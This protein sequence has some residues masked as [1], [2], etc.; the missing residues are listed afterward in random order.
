MRTSRNAISSLFLHHKTPLLL[1]II[2]ITSSI[3]TTILTGLG[4]DI[5]TDD[6]YYYTIVARNFAHTSRFTFD[7]FSETN[8]Y[9]PLL[10]WLQALLAK[11]FDHSLSSLS[12][13]HVLISFF[14]IILLSLIPICLRFYPTSHEA[15]ANGFFLSLLTTITVCFFQAFSTYYFNGMESTLAFPMLV[16][17]L[18]FYFNE[19]YWPAGC[20]AAFLVAARLD[21]MLYILFPLTLIH[22]FAH[23]FS[24]G[25]HSAIRS[26]LK[27]LLPIFVFLAPYVL[28]NHS[29]FGSWMPIHGTLKTNF[30]HLNFQP[31]NILGP[32]DR[33]IDIARFLPFR[34][35]IASLIG[36]T[37]LFRQKH[38][39]QTARTIG[40]TLSIITLTQLFGFV[41]FQKWSKPIPSWYLGLPLFTSLSGLFLGITNNLQ[42][43]YI[44]FLYTS[45]ILIVTLANIKGGCRAVSDN[46]TTQPFTMGVTTETINFIRSIPDS[47]IWAYT[48]C[49]QFAYWSGKKFI[50]LDG[51]INDF[52][53]QHHLYRHELTSYLYDHRVKYLIAGVWAQK[54]TIGYEYEPM[55]QYRACSKTFS[56]RYDSLAFYVYSYLYQTFSDIINLPFK[57]EIWRS[58]VFQ[59]G[60]SKARF[61]VYDLD[62]LEKAMEP[63]P[64]I[65]RQ[66]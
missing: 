22:L 10:F 38:L 30:P 57:S 7:G 55:Y 48:D 25:S 44:K 29:Y 66:P 32:S 20:T 51:L 47:A 15:P 50:N 13:Y 58:S 40:M 17:F 46:Q 5:F 60:N 62:A 49:G 31:N 4:H 6:A 35:L 2:A 11:C 18:F 53:Y 39:S 41:F 23:H 16:L 52:E 19:S 45:I 14:A 63:K 36:L 34:I 54:Q 28:F 59:D 12:F 37:L 26:T 21:T 3:L 56:G 64:E 43:H 24:N 27:L 1:F 42:I 61:I 9:H 8:G 65:K 33:L